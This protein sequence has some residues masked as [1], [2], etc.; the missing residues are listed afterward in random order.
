[1]SRWPEREAQATDAQLKQRDLVRS[2]PATIHVLW[3]ATIFGTIAST[4][5]QGEPP[6]RSFVMTGVIVVAAIGPALAAALAPKD[7]Q[8]TFFN[9]QPFTAAATNIKY[10]MV[11]TAD[12]KMTREP[13]GRAGAKAEG[14]WKLSND[15]FCST[16]QGSKA[17]C[18]RVVTAGESK[19]SVMKGKTLVATWTK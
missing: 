16:W 19:W 10:K 11:F 2:A 6:M 12:G 3:I 4:Q 15:G 13:I 7:I 18:Y 8:A 9:G 17:N 5:T 14:T 1:L